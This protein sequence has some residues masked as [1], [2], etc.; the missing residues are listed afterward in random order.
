MGYL[1]FVTFATMIDHATI[2]RILDSA[3]IA[4]VVSD[5]VTLRRRGVN[6][7][8]LCPFHNEKTPSF[9]VS[10]AKGI[11][12]CFGC[13]K[14]GNSV[15]FIMEHENLGYPEALKWLAKKY[16]I[17]VVE[18]EDSE[19]EKQL[20]D[21][22]ESLMIVSGF[23]QKYFTNFLWN[24]NEGR[25][26]GLSY[27]R[28]R[29]FRDDILKKFELGYSP[30]GKAPFTEA[31][32]KEGYKIEFLEKTGLTIKRDDWIRDRF[33]GRVMF[34]VHNLAGRVIA[35]G[36]RILKEDKTVAKYLNSPESEI[37]HKSKIVYGIFQAKREI[38]KSD[39]CYLVEGYTDVLSMHQAGIENVVA[40]SGTALTSEQIRMIKRFTPNITII[41]DGDAAGIK[42]SLRGIDLVL[43]EGMNVKV[44][45]LPD[46]EDPD[47]YAKKM[48]ASGF[49]KYIGD[50]ETDFIQFKTRLLLK[51]SENDPVAKA[52]L[53]TEVIRSVAV[54]PDPITRS[55]YIKEC[56]KLLD[57][58]E[59]LLYSEVQKQKRKQN[60]ELEKN[61]VRLETR[62]AVP[63][64]SVQE[65][66]HPSKLTEEEMVF[67]RFLLKFCN[68]PLFE[69]ES[70][71]KEE[72]DKVTVGEFMVHELE[73][74]ELVSE[75]QLFAVI[76]NE[77]SRNIGNS[78]FDTWKYFIYHPNS[79]VSK[80]ATN[81]LADKHNESAIW[82][83]GGGFTESE[84][85]I[86]EL[87][88]PKVINEYKSAK[89][90]LMLAEIEEEI[91][92]AS[93]DNNFDRVIEEQ[94]KYLNLKRVEKELSEKL[95]NR[96]IN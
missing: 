10:P 23:A 59:E 75:N 55:V 94:S 74:D 52:K 66:L 71:N 41:Y 9:T 86:L 37:Y 31:A 63:Q 57:V 93:K 8:G 38:S 54:I 67:L 47:S 87:L 30:D 85:D 58:K 81:L 13:G 36:G 70:E 29:S 82:K 44:L 7:L 5:F 33:A 80:L 51:E 2:E 28:E 91:S 4:D 6:L 61:Q 72:P 89:I 34:P 62:K 48:G 88:V 76:F 56:S 20:N 90:R 27:F 39:K 46:G 1:Q 95:G 26:V 11:F 64:T 14:G 35:F 32:E 18:H 65:V 3:E 45:L 22:R 24:E 43:E 21:E 78:A 25:T 69:V 16:H 84:E 79:E 15:N 42:A 68:E 49:T 19:E 73:K 60:E 77:T 92:R 53:I 83:R 96:T 50:N 17:E 12:K 40:S